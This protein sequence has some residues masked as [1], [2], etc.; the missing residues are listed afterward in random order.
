MSA[1]TADQLVALRNLAAKQAGQEVDWIRIADARAL[2]DLGLAERD[3][4]GWNIS[5]AGTAALANADRPE[6]GQGG[7]RSVNRDSVRKRMIDE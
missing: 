6:R 2:T 4:C 7:P 5:P 3:A 1:L